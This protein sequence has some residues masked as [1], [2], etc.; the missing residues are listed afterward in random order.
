MAKKIKLPNAHM[1]PSGS[2]R[3]QVMINGVRKSFVADTEDEAVRLAM[4]HKLS[5][6]NDEADLKQAHKMLTFSQAIDRYLAE[7]DSVLSPSTIKSY[8]SYQKHRIQSVMNLP[9][10]A[11]INWQ[12]VINREA[13]EVSP[14]TIKNIWGM[15]TA[16]LN[17]NKVPYKDPALPALI[18]ND[19]VFL[20][21]DDI[22]ILVKAIEGHRFEAMYLLCLHG[23]RRSEACAVRPENIKDGYIL[24]RGAKVYDKDGNLIMRQENKTYESHRNVPIM[25]DRLNVLAKEC[26]TEFMFM[27]KPS[28]T[29][30][31]LQTI[32][33]QNGLPEVNLHQLRHSYASLCYYLGI[34]EMQCMEY[35]GWNDIQVMRKIYTHLARKSRNDAEKKLKEFFVCK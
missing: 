15:V 18:K 31:P 2:W 20:E 24:V 34:S 17:D 1:L 33:R 9:L 21:P 4:L 35:G 3:C 5:G 7:R 23:L 25:I 8:K 29:T 19:P 30:H 32:C 10:S 13:K 27:G 28:S 6:S 16:V 14:K 11:N 26:S 12:Q 22:K